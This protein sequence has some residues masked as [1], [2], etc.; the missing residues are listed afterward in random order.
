[1]SWLWFRPYQCLEKDRLLVAAQVKVSPLVER[2]MWIRN[3]LKPMSGAA[4][5]LASP[6]TGINRQRPSGVGIG[7]PSTRWPHHST[8]RQSTTAANHTT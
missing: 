2:E 1:V 6:S 3:R 5:H 8:V 4:N 7:I